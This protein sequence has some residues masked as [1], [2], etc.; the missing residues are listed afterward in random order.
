MVRKYSKISTYMSDLNLTRMMEITGNDTIFT[1]SIHP[2]ES[3]NQTEK[4]EDTVY[5]DDVP[6]DLISLMKQITGNDK[7]PARGILPNEKCD[8]KDDSTPFDEIKTEEHAY[9]LGCF[10]AAGSVDNENIWKI[11]APYTRKEILP[12]L[13]KIIGEKDTLLEKNFSYS[14]F[15][16]TLY[17]LNSQWTGLAEK[18]AAKQLSPV[19]SSKFPSLSPHLSKAFLRGCLDIKGCINLMQSCTLTLNSSALLKSIEENIGVRGIVSDSDTCITFSGV[20]CLDFLAKIYEGSSPQCRLSDKYEQFC[21]LLTY[22]NS[23]IDRTWTNNSFKCLWKKTDKDALPLRKNR[24]SDSGYDLA[25]IRKEKQLNP[26]VAL[27]DTG[28]SVSPPPGYYFD[29]VPR[30]S[31]S[32]TGYMLANNTGIIDASYSGSIKVALFKMDDSIPDLVLPNYMVQLIPRKYVHFAL[33]EVNELEQTERSDKGFGS[34]ENQ[35]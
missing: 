4:H 29:V 28:I 5:F 8:K 10:A 24:C 11:D 27:Y 6:H 13:Q 32:K 15:F 18:L 30:S 3:K 31:I 25:L 16:A 19:M 9:L 35:K 33:Q 14:Y 2:D 22:Y 20:N 7:L 1:R 23:D 21:R 26:F 17:I 34:T 12:A